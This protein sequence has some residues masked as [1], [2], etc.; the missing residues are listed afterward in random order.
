MNNFK[1]SNK[2][3]VSLFY[4]CKFA[5]RIDAKVSGNE[6]IRTDSQAA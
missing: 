6:W 1:V 5:T 4:I 2:L 3:S